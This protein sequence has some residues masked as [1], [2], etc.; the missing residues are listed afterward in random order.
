MSSHHQAES[1]IALRVKAIELLLVEKGIIDPATLDTI[2]DAYEHK[3]GPHNGARI[4]A[5]AWIDPEFKHRLLADGTSA[6]A[7]MKLTGFS[8]EHMVVVENTPNIHNLIVCTLCSCYPWAILGLPPTW[9]KSF[10]YRSRAVIDPRGVLQEFGLEI[11]E[12]VEVRVWDSNADLRYLV[13]PERPPGTEKMTEDKLAGLVTRNAMIGTAKVQ[14][15][16]AP[17]D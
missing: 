5:R 11:P 16:A 10:A 9:Y 6:I 14:S 4:V 15:P 3:I 12:Q 7:E 8:S 2:I 13:L 17:I 1:D